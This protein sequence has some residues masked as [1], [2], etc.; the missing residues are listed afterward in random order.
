M[1]FV[2]SICSIVFLL[3]PVRAQDAGACSTATI[4]GTYSV[5]CT[6]FVSPAPGAPQ[7]PASVLGTVTTAWNGGVTGATKMSVGGTIVNQTV[8]GTVNV[9]SDCTGS[10]S[11]AQKLNGQPAPN[12]N[13]VF[14]IVNFGAEMNG[15]SVDQGA[16]LVCKLQL[17]QK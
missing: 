6:G 2:Y 5:T 3:A 12:L 7:M 4:R 1:R 10:V 11:Y 9:N 15:M 16:T 8:T 17:M 14:N 13:V